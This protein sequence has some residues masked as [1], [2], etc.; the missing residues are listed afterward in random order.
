MRAGSAPPREAR[1]A[2]GG[3][4]GASVRGSALSTQHASTRE[5]DCPRALRSWCSML[6]V[7][8]GTDPST[9]SLRSTA[10][11]R[12]CTRRIRTRAESVH[13]LSRWPVVFFTQNF[14]FATHH[15]HGP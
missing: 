8:R 13:A 7:A 4:Q 12:T 5:R 2:N 6:W 15:A 9:R 1:R 10:P 14:V 11:R 3:R